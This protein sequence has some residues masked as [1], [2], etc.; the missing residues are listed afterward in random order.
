VLE[1]HAV[2]G[3]YQ[4]RREEDGGPGGDA[5]DLLVL[6]EAGLG[7]P[8]DLVVLA[9]TDQGG[10]DG[11][12]VLEQGAEG[13][14]VFDDPQQVVT[15]VAEVTLQLDVDV[16]LVEPATERVDDVEQRLGRPLDLDHLTSEGIDAA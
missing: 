11:E 12:R 3:A 2:D 4:G 15:D 8:L 6:V 9:L 5:F 7:Q 14:G 10:V 1:V 13:V 16:V